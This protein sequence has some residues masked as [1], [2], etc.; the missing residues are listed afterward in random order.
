[1]KYGALDYYECYGDDL[2]N[3]I[4]L[5]FPKTYKFKDDETVIFSY[6]VFKSKAHRNQVNKKGHQ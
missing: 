4:G 5:T 3:N 6:I 1:M 2:N